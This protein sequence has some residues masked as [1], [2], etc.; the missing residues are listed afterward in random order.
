MSSKQYCKKY[1]N[2]KTKNVSSVKLCV[3][4]FLSFCFADNCIQRGQTDVVVAM[5]KLVGTDYDGF[6]V[7]FVQKGVMQFNKAD[8][9]GEVTKPIQ[10]F[11]YKMHYH[12]N[13]MFL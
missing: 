4:I 1:K 13:K 11:F 9:N 5:M 10:H 6:D 8:T 2:T 12:Q 7:N 3:L